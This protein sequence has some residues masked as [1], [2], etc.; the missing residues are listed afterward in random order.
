M[1]NKKIDISNPFIVHGYAGPEYF[2]DREKETQA[3]V[4]ALHNG[5]NLTLIAPRRIGKTG[6]IHNVFHEIKCKEE[7]VLC[8]YLDIF[9]THC[10][11]DFI[12]ALG[13]GIFEEL[14]SKGEKMLKEFT[15]LLG[16][17]RPVISVDALTGMPTVTFDIAPAAQEQTLSEIFTNIVKS[18]KRCFIA[19]DEFQQIAQYPEKGTEA[20][21]RSHIQFMPKVNF[22]FA[23]SSRH[24]MAEM[25]VSAKRPFYNSTQIMSLQ[26]I[27]RNSYFA[28]AAKFFKGK[29]GTLNREVFHY[30]YDVFDGGTWYVQTILNRLYNLN[31]EADRQ[32][33]ANSIRQVVEENALVY[34]TLTSLL[35]NQQLN[36]LRAIAK[37]G[38]VTAPTNG[39]F[40]ARYKLKAASTVNSALKTL[41]A[42]EL[43]YK[44]E[45]GYMVYDRFLALWLGSVQLMP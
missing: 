1:A 7:G 19:I 24:L 44:G 17:C 31:G 16:H 13:K 9:A 8:I 36:L 34:Q 14:Y 35:P 4:S 38:I 30:I 18:G 15:S 29:G 5:R 32:A 22:I 21:L 27:D 28:F 11:Q 37:E 43:I 33:A 25:F 39:S 42:K 45:K 20:A 41:I 6:L 26:P 3:I 2:C 10:L 12:C 40:I 23:G